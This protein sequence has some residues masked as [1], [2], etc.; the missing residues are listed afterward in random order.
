MHHSRFNPFPR[1]SSAYGAPMGRV[2]TRLWI[3]P[4]NVSL[5]ELCVAG[6]AGEYDSGGAYWG[7]G[8]REGPVWAVWVRGNGRDGVCYVRAHSRD[9]AKRKAIEC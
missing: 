3:D 7:V 1:V 8:G 6:P 4:E 9:Q 5:G 2:S